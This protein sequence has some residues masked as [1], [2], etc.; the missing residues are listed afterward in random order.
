MNMK[1]IEITGCKIPYFWY[2]NRIGKF[3]AVTMELPR[4]Y[5]VKLKDRI[6]W[7]YKEDA[8]EVGEISEL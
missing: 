7:V 8:K 4:S 1:I 6:D 5:Y 3:Y 2:E